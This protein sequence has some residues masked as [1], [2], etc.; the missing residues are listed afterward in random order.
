MKVGLSSARFCITAILSGVPI[1]A[2]QTH[3][4][5]IHKAVFFETRVRPVLVK[6]CFT[7]HTGGNIMG[8]LRLDARE[9]LLKGGNSG[10]AILPGNPEGSLLI[11]AV[12]HTHER[13]KMPMGGSKLSEDEIASLKSWVKEGAVWP[14]TEAV[15]KPSTLGGRYLI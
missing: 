15:N 14:V 11:Q 12:S 10:P 9:H 8:G 2:A 13:L 4:N 6:S 1:V 7:C 3:E 5:N